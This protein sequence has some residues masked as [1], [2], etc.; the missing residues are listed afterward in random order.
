MRFKNRSHEPEK[1]V[2]DLTPLLDISF[3]IL[4]FFILTTTFIKDNNLVIEKPEAA[5]GETTPTEVIKIR[6]TKSN[7]LYIENILVTNETLEGTLRELITKNP[8]SSLIIE[9]DKK[10]NLMP[11][12]LVIDIAKSIGID[13][14]SVS[15]T[16]N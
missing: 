1:N 6:I 2:I 12:V 10:S 11:F 3:I 7:N 9:A 16:K 5:N 15:T 14:I 4:I 13:K 8:N